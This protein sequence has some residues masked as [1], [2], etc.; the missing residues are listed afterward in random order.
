M[1]SNKQSRIIL[2]KHNKK[3][4]IKISRFE[5]F[6]FK[7]LKESLL[8]YYGAVIFYPFYDNGEIFGYAI[9]KD[10][11]QHQ[12]NEKIIAFNKIKMLARD[13]ALK[14]AIEGKK[15][16]IEIQ[17]WGITTRKI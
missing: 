7:K 4:L 15:T 5:P 16:W 1:K 11:R 13:I 17:P 9:P 8:K 6:E 3:I 10:V 2:R 14:N 12:K